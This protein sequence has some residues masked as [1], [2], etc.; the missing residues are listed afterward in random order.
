MPEARILQTK[1]FRSAM[2]AGIA[3]ASSGRMAWTGLMLCLALAFV[4]GGGTNPAIA[5][6][7]FLRPISALLF[8]AALFSLSTPQIRASKG[9]L[10]LAASCLGLVALQLMPLPPAVWQGLPGREIVVANDA[11]AGIEG[12]WRPLSLDPA[13]TSNALFSLFLPLAVLLF[14]IQLTSAKLARTVNLVLLG[15]GISGIIGL[16]Q[17]LGDPEGGLY[18]YAMTTNGAAVGLFANRNHE[19]L[20]L[21]AMFPMLAFWAAGIADNQTTDGEQRGW[22]PSVYQWLALGAALFIAPLVLVTG[23]RAGLLL[24]LLGLATVP[25]VMAKGAARAVSGAANLAEGL[26]KKPLLRIAAGLLVAGVVGLA[27]AVGR[28]EALSRLLGNTDPAAELR[29]AIIPVLKKMIDLYFP[30]GSGFGSFEAV[31]LIHEPDSLLGPAY[32]NY[33][34]NDW[35]ELVI[36]GGLPGV[37]LVTALVVMV[38][39]RMARVMLNWQ[40]VTPVG[41]LTRLGL[42]VLVYIALGSLGDYPLRVPIIQCLFALAL[43]WTF[44]PGAQRQDLAQGD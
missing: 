24:G 21:A 10:I 18:F 20:L 2:D 17:L 39:L 13:R 7:L 6:L 37:L 5:S 12:Q 31:Y 35:L 26:G 28:D 32:V 16:L 42:V 34:H 25:F 40:T 9:L 19:A 15:G 22:V 4:G 41:R 1:I 33:A 38:I 36:T 3:G 8:A 29:I 27:I 30:W 11:L 14:A 43:V 23:S 44:P